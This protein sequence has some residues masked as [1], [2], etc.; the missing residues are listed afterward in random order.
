MNRIARARLGGAIGLAAASCAPAGAA[1]AE[2]AA[3]EIHTEDVARFYAVYE[4]ANGLPTAA[5]LQRDYIDP[6]T[7]GLHHLTRVRNVNAGNIA[8]AVATQPEVAER[9]AR[10]EEQIAE[11]RRSLNRIEERL[12]E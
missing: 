8:R 4:A 11:A 3:I 12:G 7:A 1:P 2:P 10:L 9:L 6:G 5:Q